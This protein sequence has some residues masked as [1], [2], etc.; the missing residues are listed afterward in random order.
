MTNVIKTSMG[1]RQGD[2]LSPYLFVL[3]MEKLGQWLQG[4]VGEGRL[5]EVRASR[6]EPG[7]SHL[8]FANDLLLFSEACEEQFACV[9]EGLELFCK[10]SSQGINY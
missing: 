10:R 2:P 3:F 9:R 7:L 8:F 1:L 6:N 4:K 5:R